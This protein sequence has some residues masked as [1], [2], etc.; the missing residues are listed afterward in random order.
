MAAGM[1]ELECRVEQIDGSG[2]FFDRMDGS[3][4]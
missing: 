1:I 2:A 3:D 4:S